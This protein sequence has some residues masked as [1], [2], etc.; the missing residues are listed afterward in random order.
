MTLSLKD[1]TGAKRRPTR[2]ES[3]GAQA[4]AYRSQPE[5]LDIRELAK[6]RL[7]GLRTPIRGLPHEMIPGCWETFSPY[8]GWLPQQVDRR[9]YG[10]LLEAEAPVGRF[11]YF[12]AVEVERFDRLNSDWDRLEVPAQRYAVFA[13]KDHVSTLRKT[14]HS[15]FSHSLP[16]LNLDPLRHA[17]GVPLVL[18]RYEPAFDWRTG[19]GGIQVWVPLR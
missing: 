10:V 7:A 4:P 19:W 15:V 6:L 13:H 1:E 9:S 5:L 14:L 12:T 3:P 17:P 8:R 16:H 18:E 11:D 2:R